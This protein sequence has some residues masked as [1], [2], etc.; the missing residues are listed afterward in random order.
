MEA[1]PRGKV[2]RARGR[3][4]LGHG[5]VRRVGNRHPHRVSQGTQKG[6]KCNNRHVPGDSGQHFPPPHHWG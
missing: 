4:E 5:A 2:H 1:D 3:F 6:Q